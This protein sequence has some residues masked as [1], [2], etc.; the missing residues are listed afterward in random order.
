M[1][2]SES[3]RNSARFVDPVDTHDHLIMTLSIF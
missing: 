1:A 2:R 3:G